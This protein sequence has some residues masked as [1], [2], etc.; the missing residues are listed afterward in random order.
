MG[1]HYR[2]ICGSFP[3]EGDRNV[4]PKRRGGMNRGTISYGSTP[5]VSFKKKR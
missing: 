1:T 5:P 3:K 2:G 4:T